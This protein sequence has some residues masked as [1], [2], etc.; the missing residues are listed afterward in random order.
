VLHRIKEHLCNQLVATWEGGY[1]L[2]D[3]PLL[4][5]LNQYIMKVV[6]LPSGK[7]LHGLLIHLLYDTIYDIDGCSSL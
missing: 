7:L 1:F 6:A 4:F 3:F 5:V 2:A